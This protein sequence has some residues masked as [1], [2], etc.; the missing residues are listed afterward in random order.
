LLYYDLAQLHFANWAIG[1]S[2]RARSYVR[3]LHPR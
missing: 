1:G 2:P 3:Q